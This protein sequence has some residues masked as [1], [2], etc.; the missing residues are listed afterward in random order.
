M[1]A[2]HLQL[3]K[4]MPFWLMNYSNTILTMY[5]CTKKNKNFKWVAIAVGFKMLFINVLNVYLIG[6]YEENKWVQH[7]SIWSELF[8]ILFSLFMYKFLLQL[9][10]E[11]VSAVFVIA[12]VRT[13]CCWYIPFLTVSLFFHY[14]ILEHIQNV[15]TT[16]NI[17]VIIF[18]FFNMLITQ[19]AGEGIWNHIKRDNLKYPKFWRY[20][21]FLFIVGGTYSTCYLGVLSYP[22]DEAII[23]IF[24]MFFFLFFLYKKNKERLLEANSRNLVLQQ[25]MILQYYESLNEQIDLTRK[26]KHDID[27]HMQIIESIQ[28]ENHLE[29]LD[30][31]TKDL[32]EKYN[33]LEIHHYCGNVVINAL[34][35]NKSK[36]C[37]KEK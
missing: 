23:I 29:A 8:S 20:I 15:P 21:L 12:D 11:K 30:S 36:K 16:Y 5:S 26:M 27:N 37:Q 22:F 25:E 14:N 35:T 1:N 3:L 24:L 19:K 17:L 32:K 7:L 31:Y 28:K 9:S 18:I 2:V 34:I 4:M 10:W 6:I 33:Q 13:F